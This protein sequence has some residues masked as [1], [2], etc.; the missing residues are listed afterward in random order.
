MGEDITFPADSARAGT[1]GCQLTSAGTKPWAQPTG[2][3]RGGL[4]GGAGA[5][6]QGAYVQGAP[7]VQSSQVGP[8]MGVRK[9]GTSGSTH[10]SLFPALGWPLEAQGCGSPVEPTNPY[11]EVREGFPE[12]V[13]PELRLKG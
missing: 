4:A 13:M 1:L 12:E 8:R 5:L 11:W 9:A 3:G 2:W 10:A 6:G 7:S